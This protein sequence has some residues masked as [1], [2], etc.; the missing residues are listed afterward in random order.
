M[1]RHAH[2]PLSIMERTRGYILENFL[3]TQSDARLGETEGLFEKG[4]IDSMGVVELVAFIENEFGITVGDDEITEQNFGTL[5]GISRYVL[6]K[7][8]ASQA[9]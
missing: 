1:D 6:D 7:S 8:G 9:A 5:Q 3:Y 2:T 4:I